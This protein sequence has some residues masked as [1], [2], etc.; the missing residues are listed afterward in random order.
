[1]TETAAFPGLFCH[2][3]RADWG[4]G[5]VSGESD[6]KRTYLFDS[7]EERMM[8]RGELDKMSRIAHLNEEQRRTLAR[9][10][11]LVAR[12]HAPKTGVVTLVDEVAALRQ[13]FP[14]GFADPSW[15]AQQPAGRVREQLAGAQKAL[16]RAS[17][18]AQLNS[19]QVEPLWAAAAQVLVATGWVPADQLVPAPSL[20]LGLLAANV[21]ELLHGSA[22]IEQ[23][24]DGFSVAFETA[25][26]RPARWETTTGLL[27]LLD[28]D[29]HVLVDLASFR[30]VLKLIG[31]KGTVSQ[32]PSGAG[33]VRCLHAARVIASKL[34]EA[35]EV[36][37]DLL[38]VHDFVRFSQKLS[39]PARKPKAAKAP[40]KKKSRSVDP[41]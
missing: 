15:S 33:Y 20:G 16:S 32:N 37:R 31:A 8:G 7:G 39:V 14:Q 29:H 40:P 30:K 24:V 25:F 3:T 27:A 21:R 22:S 35:G 4:V 38:D 1:M 9:L 23:R 19:Q 28:P 17:L 13:A 18:D 6:G 11:A 41:D 34:N 36:P 12:R 10:T 2:P 5:V 26:R